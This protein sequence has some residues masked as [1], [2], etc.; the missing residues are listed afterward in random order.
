M[1]R[2]ILDIKDRTLGGIQKS[3]I[4]ILFWI[5]NDNYKHEFEEI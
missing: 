3:C 5:L 4:I 1:F 2:G